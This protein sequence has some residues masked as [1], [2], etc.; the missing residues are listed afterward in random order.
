MNLDGI[1]GGKDCLKR[2]ESSNLHPL[3][4]SILK[5]SKRYEVCL[6]IDPSLDSG[7]LDHFNSCVSWHIPGKSVDPSCLTSC[8]RKKGQKRHCLGIFQ[9]LFCGTLVYD[10]TS[11]VSHK[12]TPN[13][14]I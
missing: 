12:E 9:I 4:L 6:T 11:I 7:T 5:P 3:V 8:I 10:E 1:T 13:N 14:H 2:V